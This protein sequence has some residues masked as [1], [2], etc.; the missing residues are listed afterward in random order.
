MINLKC[1]VF[2]EH[3]SSHPLCYQ[4]ALHH[5]CVFIHTL[6]ERELG[7]TTSWLRSYAEDTA[8]RPARVLQQAAEQSKLSL[9]KTLRPQLPSAAADSPC[10]N[11][12]S[13]LPPGFSAI[14]V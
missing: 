7:N 1:N 4:N 5:K 9:S 2:I 14:F 13:Q 6:V 11:G 3:F 10:M 8:S 12:Y